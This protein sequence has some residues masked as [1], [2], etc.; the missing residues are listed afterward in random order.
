MT[1]HFII[2]TDTASDDAVALV[3]AMRHPGVQIE[4]IT[5]VAG[6]VPVDQGVQNALYT[7]ELCQQAVPVYRGM[8]APL[9][10]P[11][12]TAQFVHGQD[13]MGD[14]GLPLYGRQPA[15]GDAVSVLIETIHRFAGN[16]TLLALGPLTNVATALRKEPMIADEVSECVIMG[17]TGRGHGNITPVGEYNLW[18]DPEA[19]KIVFE[20]G[21]PLKMVGWDISRTY[22]V[23]DPQNTAELR[24]IGTP[25]AEFCVDIQD[26]LRK[27]AMTQSKL[28]GFDL[29]DPIATAIALQPEIATETKHLFVTIETQSELCRGQSVV[30]HNAILGQ[31]PNTEVVLK[32]S[33]ELFWD[34]LCE[35]VRMA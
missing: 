20:S 29:P 10:R 8:P 31:E 18:A 1:R 22:A 5:V 19:A 15:A 28:T 12:E 3:M 30:D 21:M 27:F 17:G 35:A 24:A 2:D 9:V 6:N 11:L 26:A 13:G 32:A 4:A 23:L 34:M 7:V 33:R 16:I 25:L 14:I